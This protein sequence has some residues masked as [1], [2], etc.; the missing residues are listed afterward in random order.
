M[1]FAVL[2]QE[3][4]A[5]LGVIELSNVSFGPIHAQLDFSGEFNVSLRI[6]KDIDLLNEA[7]VTETIDIET[8][9]NYE[10]AG[11]LVSLIGSKV[12]SMNYQSISFRIDFEKPQDQSLVINLLTTDFDPI[13]VSCSHHMNPRE[14]VWRF[15]VN[16]TM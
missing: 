8:K 13:Q 3:S 6:D 2:L 11:K 10:S 4:L 12:C 16:A 5:A 14:L 1:T 15:T 7:N 9:K